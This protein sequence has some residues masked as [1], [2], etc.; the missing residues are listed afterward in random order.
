M[1]KSSFLQQLFLLFLLINLLGCLS[2]KNVNKAA[3]KPLIIFVTGD[4]EYSGEETL[5]L[6]AKELEKNY[7]FRTTVLKASPTIILR[8]IS[9]AWKH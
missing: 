5:P 8:K 1:K 4:H 9:P 2:A 6:I 7:G 3:E